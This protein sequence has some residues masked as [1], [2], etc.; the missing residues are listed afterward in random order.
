MLKNTTKEKK[1]TCRKRPRAELQEEMLPP[2]LRKAPPLR[3]KP[4]LQFR[5]PAIPFLV[6]DA[7]HLTNENTRW[8]LNRSVCRIRPATLAAYRIL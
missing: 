1:F 4:G 2:P 3:I 8:H 5:Y 7:N 6:L